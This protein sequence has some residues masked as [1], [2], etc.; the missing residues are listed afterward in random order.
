[1]AGPAC[2]IMLLGGC[3]DAMLIAD[4][5]RYGTVCTDLAHYAEARCK[6]QNRQGGEA[7]V[8]CQVAR[9]NAAGIDAINH[10]GAVYCIE[11]FRPFQNTTAPLFHHCPY[12]LTRAESKCYSSLG[13][14]LG[15][16]FKNCVTEEMGKPSLAGS[17]GIESVSSFEIG[18]GYELTP[19]SSSDFRCTGAV[20]VREG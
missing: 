13:L 1:L 12:L 10:D 17:Y 4:Y 16:E 11:P 8:D 5:S 15:D 9:L 18:K 2:L 20:A 19:S 7:V 6:H 3:S 14:G